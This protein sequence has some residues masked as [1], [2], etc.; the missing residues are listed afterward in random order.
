M[1]PL[2]PAV[3]L[4][5]ALALTLGTAPPAA[6]DPT[7]AEHALG[8]TASA[9]TW[10]AAGRAADRTAGQ[11]AREAGTEADRPLQ[12]LTIALDPGHQL[13]NRRHSEQVNALVPAGGFRKACNTTGTATA[14]GLPESTVVFRLAEQVRR[15]LEALGA[16]VPMTR[17]VD[18]DDRWGPCIDARGEFG[19]E[20]GAQ[21]MV[22]LHADGSS[23]TA[24]GFHVIAPERRAPWTTDIAAD[25][26]RLA[27]ALRG[28]LVQR[29][30]PTAGYVAGGSGLDVRGDL[31]TLNLS[32]V[33]V[34]MVEIGNMRNA[35]D[36]ER[37]TSAAGRAR[38][39]AALVL[40]IRRYLE[41]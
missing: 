36:A 9:R 33:P 1:R 11:A 7:G 26:L 41:R 30:V 20:V 19:G 18:S 10:D 40:G 22:S 31:G 24:S 28:A 39:T 12:G 6:A 15:R 17:T 27:T 13:G 25:S 35:G 38:Y 8:P 34:V 2:L 29:G 21:L 4:T 3:A 23:D 5:G 14:D 37:M 32:D 16:R